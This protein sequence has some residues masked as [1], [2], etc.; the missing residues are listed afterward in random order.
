MPGHTMGVDMD[1]DMDMDMD[2]GGIGYKFIPNLLLTTGSLLK[3]YS[4]VS[5]FRV[6]ITA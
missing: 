1:M 4:A 6:L 3:F 5:H 2:V